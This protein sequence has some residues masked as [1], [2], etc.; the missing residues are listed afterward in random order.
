[1]HAAMYTATTMMAI[2]TVLQDARRILWGMD[3]AMTHATTVTATTIT[4]TV[5][6]PLGVLLLR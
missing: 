1:M 2:V 6:V 5:T 3:N 4:A